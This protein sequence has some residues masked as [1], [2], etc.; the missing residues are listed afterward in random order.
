[1]DAFSILGKRIFIGNK[2]SRFDK[3][4]KERQRVFNKLLQSES[5]S[6]ITTINYAIQNYDTNN[7]QKEALSLDDFIY[8]DDFEFYINNRVNVDNYTITL[9]ENETITLNGSVVV[10]DELV[11]VADLKINDDFHYYQ[12]DSSLFSEVLHIV[13][14]QLATDI[15]EHSQVWKTTLK[16]LNRYFGNKAKELFDNLLAHKWKTGLPTLQGYLREDCQTQFPR[17]SSLVAIKKF[18]ENLDG[19][20]E[21][22]FILKFDGIRKAQKATSISIELG[23]TIIKSLLE[24]KIGIDPN[25][26]FINKIGADLRKQLQEKCLKQGKVIKI[27][28]NLS[29]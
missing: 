26:E 17:V 27:E 12:N 29:K 3:M 9:G 13:H 14:P 10:E 16:E 7:E 6:S 22:D 4:V 15:D 24:S 20:R 28:K 21:N 11:D 19:F 5:R 2:D 25:Q 23:R 1:M 8:T 18:C